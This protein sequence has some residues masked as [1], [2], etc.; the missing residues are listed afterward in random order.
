MTYGGVPN[1]LV[2][3]Q[4]GE[5]G[6][7][8]LL[9]EAELALGQAKVC[10]RNTAKGRRH[11]VSIENDIL[12]PHRATDL[13][14]ITALVERTVTAAWEIRRTMNAGGVA[15]AKRPRRPRRSAELA[16]R[17]A[18]MVR[19]EGLSW[20]VDG[21]VVEVPMARTARKHRIDLCEA[22]GLY[23]L[24]TQV[25]GS[26][27][28]AHSGK[29]VRSLSYRSW[30]WNA[31]SELVDFSVNDRGR[32]IGTIEQPMGSADDLELRMYVE[33]LARECDR[34]EYVLTGRDLR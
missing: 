14:D 13:G 2:V 1:P 20:I 22:D 33:A 24:R 25:T 11:D 9:H 26:S 29:D 27:A 21:A 6:T 32:L 30:H 34:A 8:D 15:L 19:R 31:L 4:F 16:A 23:V 7:A 3:R 17:V 5:P 28:F 10:A 18:A 12:L